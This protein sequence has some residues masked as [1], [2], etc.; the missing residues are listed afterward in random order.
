MNDYILNFSTVLKKLESKFGLNFTCTNDG[1][2]IRSN[3][4]SV[5][6]IFKND[7]VDVTFTVDG[8]LYKQRRD[9]PLSYDSLLYEYNLLTNKDELVK[10]DSNSIKEY[11]EKALGYKINVK[12]DTASYYTYE[13]EYDHKGTFYFYVCHDLLTNKYMAYIKTYNHDTSSTFTDEFDTLDEALIQLK[14]NL[15]GIIVEMQ[16]DV[17]FFKKYVSDITHNIQSDKE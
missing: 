3:C 11:I 6:L 12:K 17:D 15:I 4:G 13:S 8:V 10:Y 14:T 2:V 7:Y 1:D 9:M 16:K 5:L